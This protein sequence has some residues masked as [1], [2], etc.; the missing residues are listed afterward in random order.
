MHIKS[1]QSSLRLKE[2]LTSK[3]GFH[4]EFIGAR[5][6]FNLRDGSRVGKLAIGGQDRMQSQGV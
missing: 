3:K 6:W 2:Y 1:H 5:L 4:P